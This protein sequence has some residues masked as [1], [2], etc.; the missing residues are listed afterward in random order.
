MENEYEQLLSDAYA[1]IKPTEFCDR[2][3]IKK[4]EGMHEGNKT[5]ITNFAQICCGL[6]RTPEHVARFLFK[7]LASLGNIDGE[8]LILNRKM[9]SS[10]VNE[11]IEKYA[12]KFV[13][14]SNCGKP[15]TE[16]MKESNK[17]FLKCLACGI[18]KE[19]N[20]I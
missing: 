4:A 2:F 12:E 14:C 7:E 6:R 15:D 20:D 3:D 8:R 18:K 13:K 10:Q 19:I 17:T 9:P 1:K 5:I 11:K 16:I